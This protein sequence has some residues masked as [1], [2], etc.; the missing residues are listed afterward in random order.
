MPCEERGSNAFVCCKALLPDIGGMRNSDYSKQMFN[1]HLEIKT[2]KTKT[3]TKTTTT[4]KTAYNSKACFL[5]SPMILRTAPALTMI[6]ASNSHTPGA[7]CGLI[8]VGIV[9]RTSLSCECYRRIRVQAG[10]W[11]PGI[12]D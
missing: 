6:V 11:R 4:T 7:V 1:D 2:T 8:V 9:V 10:T 5:T 3:K 12:A